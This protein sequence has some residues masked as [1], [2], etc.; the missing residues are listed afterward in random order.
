MF[1]WRALILQLHL[2]QGDASNVPLGSKRYFM[3]F[4]DTSMLTEAQ[5]T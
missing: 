2:L 5:E 1:V 4:H 3:I